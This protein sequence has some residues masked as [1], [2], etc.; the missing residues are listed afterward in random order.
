M[1]TGPFAFGLS[2]LYVFHFTLPFFLFF[3]FSVRMNSSCTVHAYGF[4]M[5]ELL[6]VY[7]TST[8]LVSFFFL[9]RMN[10]NCTVH[11]PGFTVQETKCTA[12]WTYKH[13][14]Q[15]TNIK[16]KYH[17]TIHSFKNY[18]VIVFS[19]FSFQFLAK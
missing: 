9:A 7:C 17:G 3:F 19:V 15:K 18:F 4:T 13:F 8:F 6:L 2:H 5:Q 12:H 10:S 16:N 11:A 14:V 1:T